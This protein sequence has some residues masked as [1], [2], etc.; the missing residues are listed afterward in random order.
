MTQLLDKLNAF[1][2]KNDI[3][4]D[5]TVL[6]ADASTR[7]YFRIEWFGQTAVACVYPD[8]F[9]EQEHAYVDVTGAVPSRRITCRRIIRG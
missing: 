4:N 8:A 6:S 3:P 1:L 5:V 7:E 2:L 9:D